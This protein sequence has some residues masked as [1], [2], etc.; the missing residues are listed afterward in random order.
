[1]ARSPDDAA[2]A[3]GVDEG[4][5]TVSI[6][7]ASSSAENGYSACNYILRVD[8]SH[9]ANRAQFVTGQRPRGCKSSVRRCCGRRSA[10]LTLAFG[11]LR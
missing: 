10:T 3:P 9:L 2:P 7:E 4:C 1:M 5:A 8:S 11:S 6:G